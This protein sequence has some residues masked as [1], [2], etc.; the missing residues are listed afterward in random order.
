MATMENNTSQ[1]PTNSLALKTGQVIAK[2]FSKLNLLQQSMDAGVPIPSVKLLQSANTQSFVLQRVKTDYLKGGNPL[3]L[4]SYVPRLSLTQLAKNPKKYLKKRGKEVVK[5]ARGR[6]KQFAINLIYDLLKGDTKLHV[7]DT[8]KTWNENLQSLIV[9]SKKVINSDIVNPTG[10]NISS[11]NNSPVYDYLQLKAKV[12]GK[13]VTFIDGHAMV[14]LSRK[15]NIILTQVQGRD[16]TR[17]EYIS[18]GDYELQVSGKIVSPYPDVYPIE[19][20]IKFRKLMEHTDLLGCTSTILNAFNIYNILVTNFDLSQKEG[21]ANVQ[22]YSFS[23][24][25]ELSSDELIEEERN[26]DAINKA[27]AELQKVVEERQAAL[28]AQQNT[29]GKITLKALIGAVNPAAFVQS[30]KWI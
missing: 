12:D 11:L 7:N 26:F 6:T 3:S 18:A 19:D 20:V 21:F 27:K 13:E 17:K 9:E 25:F 1:K 15:K 16:L 29:S 8:V 30:Q 28:T 4:L 24:V 2:G 23:A 14:R 22:N 10:N 5:V